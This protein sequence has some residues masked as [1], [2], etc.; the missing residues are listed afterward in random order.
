MFSSVVVNVSLLCVVVVAF[1]VSLLIYFVNTLDV[2]W[3]VVFDPLV[4]SLV[5]RCHPGCR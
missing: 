3:L 5:T 4:S 1:M 2:W